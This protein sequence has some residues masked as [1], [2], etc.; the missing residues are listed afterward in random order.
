MIGEDL[1]QY[2]EDGYEDP[3][4]STSGRCSSNYVDYLWLLAYDESIWNKSTSVNGQILN[5]RNS[6]ESF[7]YSIEY[8]A[9]K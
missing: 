1:E 2:E 5:E 8:Y 9:L 3:S 6:K 7:Q 4:C